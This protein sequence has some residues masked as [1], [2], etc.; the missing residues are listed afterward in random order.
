M[1]GAFPH[2]V[3]YYRIVEHH[4]FLTGNEVPVNVKQLYKIVGTE[5]KPDKWGTMLCDKC[6]TH[7]RLGDIL[8]IGGRAAK[9]TDEMKKRYPWDALVASIIKEGIKVPVVLERYFIKG[10]NWYKPVEGKHRV[11]ACSLIEPFSNEVLIPAILVDRDNVFSDY[12][13]DEA[14]H[15]GW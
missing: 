13:S 11:T 2:D 7:I 10:K 5:R 9:I 8:G 15:P 14:K 6:V 3:F 4:R 1:R 12:M